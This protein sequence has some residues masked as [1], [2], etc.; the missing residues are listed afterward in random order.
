MFPSQC[1]RCAARRPTASTVQRRRR[2]PEPGAVLASAAVQAAVQEL[3]AVVQAVAAVA[4]VVQAV[5]V[6]AVEVEGEAVRRQRSTSVAAVSAA[7]SALNAHRIR[8]I[9]HNPKMEIFST[10]AL[11]CLRLRAH[12]MWGLY[13]PALGSATH[14][15]LFS[16]QLCIALSL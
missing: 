9:A 8:L 4:A 13:G 12:V 6:E 14:A 3:A 15:S 1:K 5:A 2:A 7:A 11:P 16:R 10:L